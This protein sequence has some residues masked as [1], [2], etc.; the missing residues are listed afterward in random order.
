MTVLYNEQHGQINWAIMYMRIKE[1][2]Y[3]KNTEK[4]EH[5]WKICDVI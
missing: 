2:K 3:R 5:K 1:R 4:N